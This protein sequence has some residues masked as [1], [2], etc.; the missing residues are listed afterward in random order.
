MKNTLTLRSIRRRLGNIHAYNSP[1]RGSV[2]RYGVIV[3]VRLTDNLP[4]VWARG[5]KKLYDKAPP[6]AARDAVNGNSLVII[7]VTNELDPASG[8][9]L[10][11]EHHY[12]T[13]RGVL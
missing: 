1:G 4:F 13:P 10:R 8:R 12:R 11:V 2:R 5:E 9:M 3:A 7:R 6:K